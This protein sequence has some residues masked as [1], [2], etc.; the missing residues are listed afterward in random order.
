M[1]LSIKDLKKEYQEGVDSKIS[2]IDGLNF[3][4]PES[5]VVAIVGGSGVGKSTLL[6]LLGGLD[7]PTSGTI[8][9]DRVDITVLKGDALSDFRGQ[10]IG[11]VFQFHHLLPEF[12]ALE[13]VTMPLA[14]Q[15]EDERVLKARGEQI[16]DRVGLSHRLHHLP[17]ALSGGE[18]QRVAIARALI[19]NPA[20]VLLDEPTGNLDITN[21]NAI[22]NLLLELNREAK[23]LM[24]VV[25][26][27][28]ALASAFDAAYEMEPRGRLKMRDKG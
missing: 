27:S 18:Q 21:A 23:N 25:T 9:I 15:G 16:L 10:K 3:D 4:F 11:F 1:R 26:H 19:T 24:I 13:N 5:G 14:I 6:Q 20:L 17:K 7:K 22:K 12:S 28:P 8:E 2:I